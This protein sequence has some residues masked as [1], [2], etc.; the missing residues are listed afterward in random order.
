[1]RSVFIQTPRGSATLAFPTREDVQ[2][3]RVGDLA[4]D[5]FGR[6]SVVTEIFAQ[7]DDI[8]GNAFVCFYVKFGSGLCSN[9][10]KENELERTLRA[11]NVATSND[12]RELE[13]VARQGG[14]DCAAG[15]VG[16]LPRD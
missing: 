9:S 13:R 12:L 8:R 2:N 5:C 3:L 11:S 1:M 6:S 10:L 7:R 15:L 4:P 16:I 14:G